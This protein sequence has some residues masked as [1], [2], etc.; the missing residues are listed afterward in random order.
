MTLPSSF[1]LPSED[2]EERGLSGSAVTDDDAKLALLD[3]KAHIVQR[4]YFVLAAFIYL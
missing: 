1:T 2:V 4:V 3:G